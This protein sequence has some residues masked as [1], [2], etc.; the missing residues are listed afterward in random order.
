MYPA[1]TFVLLGHTESRVEE[2]KLLLDGFLETG[3]MTP[4]DSE[5][6]RSRLQWFESF[7]GRRIAQ[8]ALRATSSLA[9]SSRAD[10]MLRSPELKAIK[11]LK[12]RALSAPPSKIQST[13][14]HTWLLFT[15]GACKGDDEKDGT[16]G[17]ILV[18]PE[19]K[20]CKYFSERVPGQ[21]LNK[22]L[23]ESAHPIFE[24][25][26]LPVWCAL[27]RWGFLLRR[28]Q[29]VVYMDNEAARGALTNGATSTENG[30]RI[31]QDFVLREMGAP[32]KKLFLTGT[33]EQQPG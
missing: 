16:I 22:L 31:I 3:S 19:G 7:T 5:R 28:S 12:D 25:E 2:L 6:L 30:R 1:V 24:L 15:D 21:F 20:L 4:K 13:N 14:L 29:C 32:N 11:F 26:L 18:S 33:Y 8:Q 23:K 9:S 27:I 10:N 17:A